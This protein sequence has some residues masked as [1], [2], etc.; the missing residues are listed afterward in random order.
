MRQTHSIYHHLTFTQWQN[1]ISSSMRMLFD[2]EEGCRGRLAGIR[3]MVRSENVGGWPWCRTRRLA[4][5]GRMFSVDP[6]L[7]F[8]PDYHHGL[9][10][11]R[12]PPHTANHI[13]I[14]HH[15][16]HHRRILPLSDADGD[17][18]DGVPPLTRR[19]SISCGCLWDIVWDVTY[20][21]KVRDSNHSNC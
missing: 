1:T 14:H 6:S 15:L 5:W 7:P 17:R 12:I 10:A 8:I 2:R 20:L 4:G 11:S 13:I 3:W 18:G 16:L 21:V 9:P 19:K